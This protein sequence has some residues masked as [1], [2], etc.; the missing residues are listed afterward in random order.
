MMFAISGIAARPTVHNMNLPRNEARCI[1]ESIEVVDKKPVYP[2]E[3]CPSRMGCIRFS[4][5]LEE[6]ETNSGAGTFATHYQPGCE[7]FIPTQ[8]AA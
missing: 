4:T 2:G 1:G 8:E 7:H 3:I 5:Y 6:L